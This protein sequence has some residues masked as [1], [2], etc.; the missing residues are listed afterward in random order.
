MIWR[1]QKDHRT[2]YCFC[3]VK[4][5]VYKKKNKYKIDYPSLP[6]AIRRVSHSA[7]IPEPFFVQL[8]SLEDLNNDKE[9]NDSND[10]D[11][12]TEDSL[13]SKVLDQHELN[14]LEQNLGLYKKVS[15]LLAPRLNEKKL[16][17]KWA[18][19]FYFRSSESRFLQYFQSKSWF[20]YCHNI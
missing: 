15:K 7:E 12:E 14:V 3:L 9:L 8:P 13:A 4:T 20:L 2:D 10:G 1:E 5:S 19:V 11:F 17:G 16:L 18:K 6:S